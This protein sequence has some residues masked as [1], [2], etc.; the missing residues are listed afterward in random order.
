M[1]YKASS[2][3]PNLNEIDILSTSRNPFQAQVNTLGTSVKA[4]SVNILSGDGATKI[5]NQP[6][7]ALGQEIRNK[8]QLSL[9]LTVPKSGDQVTFVEEGK[10]GLTTT[11]KCEDG[12]TLQNGKDYQWNIRMYENHSPRTADED[13]TTLVCSG[14]TVGSTTSVIWVDLSN[15]SKES[16]KQVV[17]DQLKYDRWIE[18]SASGKNDGMMAITLPNE[19]DLAYPTT[20]PYRE[21]RQINWVYTDL[22]WDKDVIKIELTESFTYNYTNGKTFTLYNVSDQHT[23]NN[24]YVE[25]NDDIELG[26]YI[27]LNSDDSVKRKIIGYGQ[28]TGEIRLQEGFA[29]VPKNGDTYKLWTKDLTSSSS[30]FSQKTYHS[31]AERK[32][33]G[34]PITN[35]NFKIMT[36]YWN[37]EADHQI[38]VQPNINIKSDA[39][40]PPQIVWENGVRLNITQKISTLGQYVAGKKTDITFNKLDNTQWLLKL[41][42]KNQNL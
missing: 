30:Q 13:P 27:S 11:A 5:L 3:S 4:Y 29:T 40:N 12:Q 36:S 41:Q 15:I 9:T 7:Q 6:S 39:L 21:R 18:I 20:W 23:L 38:F 14:F 28:E 8:E 10:K 31:S 32:V 26:N 16:D 34:T 25:P 35:P 19:D 42:I 37:S 33:G 17:K 1:I 2:L 24:F 22:G